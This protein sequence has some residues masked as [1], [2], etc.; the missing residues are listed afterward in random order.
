MGYFSNGAEGLGYVA[1]YCKKCVHYEGCPIW[2]W[3]LINNYIQA[4]RRSW[5]FGQTKTVKA[6][7]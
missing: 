1:K 6:R 2:L 5:R 7:N 4:I 3:H